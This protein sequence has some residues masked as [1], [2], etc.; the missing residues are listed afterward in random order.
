MHFGRGGGSRAARR[1]WASALAGHGVTLGWDFSRTHCLLTETEQSLY[2]L[3]LQ[4]SLHPPQKSY[5][6]SSLIS[7]L[8]IYICVLLYTHRCV[9]LCGYFSDSLGR[10]GGQQVESTTT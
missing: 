6:K 3:L 10:A 4:L 9:S 5:K 7:A 2:F 8:Q 1:L